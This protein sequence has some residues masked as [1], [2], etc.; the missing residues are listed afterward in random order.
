MMQKKA[1]VLQGKLRERIIQRRRRSTDDSA[2]WPQD[3]Q[4][5]G[6]ERAGGGQV[7]LGEAHHT[8]MGSFKKTGNCRVDR[9]KRTKPNQKVEL[10]VVKSQERVNPHKICKL[11]CPRQGGRRSSKGSVVGDTWQ[12]QT[13]GRDGNSKYM[14]LNMKFRNTKTIK[15]NTMT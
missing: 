15:M 9:V 10:L 12:S 5:M 6:S 1:S 14:K 7:L 3:N 4:M 8:E 11:G 13:T 2:A